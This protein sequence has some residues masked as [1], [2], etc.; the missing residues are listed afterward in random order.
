MLFESGGISAGGGENWVPLC[1]PAFNNNGYL[2]MYVS[3][4]DGPSSSDASSQPADASSSSGGQ[5]AIILVSPDKESFFELKQMRDAVVASLEKNGLLAIIR[6][7][8]SA[9]RPAIPAI[10]AGSQ[11][12]HFLYKSRANVQFSMSA[13]DP[14]FASPIARRRLMTLYHQLHASVHAK[15]SA[16]R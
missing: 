15:H 5:T 13:L 16:M 11:V 4:I 3:F 14:V 1:L 9:G 8:A 12:S 10:A 2:Y 6:A 7:A